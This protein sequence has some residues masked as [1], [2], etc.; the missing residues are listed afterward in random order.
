MVEGG[1]I[2]GTR[3]GRFG[4]LAPWALAALILL[5]PFL[6]MA[7]TDQVAW[8]G[9]DFALMGAILF[10]A[11]GAYELASRM[12][13]PSAYR[14][15]VAV[16]IV[17]ALFLV[18]MNLAVGVIGSEDDPANLMYGGVIA[19]LSVGSLAVRFR[20]S[21]MARVLGATALAQATAGAIA[22]IAGWGSY[23]ANWP[24]VIVVL[25]AGFAGL[26]LAAAWLFRKAARDP[27]SPLAPP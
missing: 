23:G 5:L 1:D 27:T 7:F 21:G 17:T 4:R 15:A 11:C 14:T 22:L 18:W 9:T 3:R 2:G 13:A 24:R 12:T 16:A 20:P 8:D 6:A 25:S 26:W 19:I 10:G